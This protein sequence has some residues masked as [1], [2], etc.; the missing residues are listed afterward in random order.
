[1]FRSTLGNTRRASVGAILSA[2][3]FATAAF[4]QITLYVSSSCGDDAWTGLSPVCQGPDG[5]KATIQAGINASVT[6]DTVLVADGTYT[7][8]PGNKWLWFPFERNST[9][10]S[11][12]GPENCII[13]LENDGLAFFFV[14][15]EPPE[16][17]VDGFTI[18]N[19]NNTEGG[20]IYFHHHSRVIIRNCIL[21]G[22]TAPGGGAIA[23]DNDSSPTIINCVITGNTAG[24]NGGAVVTTG[25]ST[26]TFINCTITG[27][28]AGWNGGAVFLNGFRGIGPTFINCTIADNTAGREG[29]GLF[30]GGFESG[31]TVNNSIIWGNSG[32]Q[33]TG[34]GAIS[35]RFSDVQGGFVGQGNIDDDP[36][37]VDPASG[38]YH[39]ALGSPAI[40]AGDNTAVPTGVTTDLDGNPRFVDDPGTPNTGVPG[41]GFAEIVDMGA[42]EFQGEVCYADCDGN[43]TLDIFD[44]LCFQNSF[45]LGEP[46]ACDCDP[47][48]VCDIFDF[49][50]FQNAFVAGCP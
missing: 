47:D 19:G 34:P 35:V 39:I 3:G 16:A 9:L 31:A 42:Y 2:L 28:T 24:F 41:N 5:P 20:A 22:N 17:V 21:T 45:V 26:P 12:N 38:D 6:G 29:G 11:E 44:F 1:M 27:N 4:G 37:F 15:D 49:L 30:A 8:F 10:R 50:C 13:D 14:G 33:I 32:D 7:G 40:D 25:E 18:T 36:L 46:Y 43:G 23:C 48:P